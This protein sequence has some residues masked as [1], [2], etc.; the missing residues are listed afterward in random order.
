[1]FSKVISKFQ[2]SVETL[3]INNSILNIPRNFT[4]NYFLSSSLAYKNFQNVIMF[5]QN[6]LKI[7][8]YDSY[9]LKMFKIYLFNFYVFLAG[10]IN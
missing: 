3:K 6:F 4:S 7:H 9:W 2:E 10:E 1:M 8:I 5:H